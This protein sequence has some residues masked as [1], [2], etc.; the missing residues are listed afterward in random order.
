MQ[1]DDI[2]HSPSP[3]TVAGTTYQKTK[4]S[5]R[6]RIV[7][8]LALILI[9]PAIVLSLIEKLSLGSKVIAVIAILVYLLFFWV[10]WKVFITKETT[11]VIP[12]PQTPEQIHAAQEAE[13]KANEQLDKWWVRYPFGIGLLIFAGYLS[14][15]HEYK[16][17]IPLLIGFV[18][19]LAMRELLLVSIGIGAI[20]L[21][22]SGLESMPISLAII[23][24]AVIIA[25]AI[26]K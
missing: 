13:R 2:N 8:A 23:V 5:L 20:W 18:G 21:L 4:H 3:P 9:G 11:E 25:S 24:G 1:N 15:D 16:W 22:L 26:K 7:Y 19:L 6:E 12:P 14:S 10:A 17:W